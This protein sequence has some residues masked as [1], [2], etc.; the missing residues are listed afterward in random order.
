MAKHKKKKKRQGTGGFGAKKLESE[1]RRAYACAVKKEWSEAC[2]ILEPLSQQYPKSKKVWQY[3][4]GSS[5]EI[6]NMR[7]YQK[8]CEG[9]FKVEPTGENAYGLGGVYL[10]NKHPLMALQ[11]FRQAL[12]L[13]PNHEL[14][15]QAREAVTKLEPILQRTLSEMELR[16]EEGLEIALL[17]E[18]GQAYMEQG[19]YATAR[20]AEEKVL[21][22]HPDMVS[23]RNNLSLIS[24]M[25]GDVE[26][27]MAMAKAVLEREGSNIHA[28]SN[29]IHFL[30]IAGDSAGARVYGEKLKASHAEAWD[31]WSK[32]V[33]GLTY[34][35]DD[36]GIV[37][38]WKQAQAEA[39]EGEE[40]LISALFYHLSAVAL[41]R[42]GSVESARAQWKIALERDASLELARENLRNIGKPISLRHGAWPFK[43]E[44]WLMPKSVAELQQMIKTSVK[45]TQEGKLV[46]RLKDFLAGHAEVVGLLPRILERGGPKG[47]EFVVSTAEQL[48]TPELLNPL[49]EFALSQN[50][51]DQ[52][53]NRAAMLAAQAKLIP[54]DRVR[55]WTAGEW[56]ELMLMAYEFHGETMVKHKRRVESLL[57]SALF[58]LRQSGEKPALEAEA[59]L[60][61]ALVLEPEAP[62]LMYNLTVAFRQQGREEESKAL[63]RD[64]VTRHPDYIFASASLAKLLLEGGD[65]EAAEELL[66]PFLTRDRFHV[67]EFSAFMDAYIE[68][69]LVK[70][71]KKLARS[72]LG[73]WSRVNS[74]VQYKDPQ[75]DYWR[76]R[77]G[78]S[79]KLSQP[80]G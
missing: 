8:A 78:R 1:L 4:L 75:L 24:W 62:D 25:E 76:K 32:K 11:T 41:A 77:L 28:L 47:Q 27:A 16:E 37:E 64:L 36:V 6:G 19:D 39:V 49:K 63:L 15:A 22:K 71:D 66:K 58:L 5:W 30:V 31:G 56:R 42:T 17:H 23:A 3:L 80:F 34:L 7:L 67:L 13:E 33:E 40:E 35:A 53:R 69:M 21:E 29:L 74:Q 68:V 45:A 2:Q 43:W 61:K 38:V 73:M 14:A 59:L 48:K 18:R 44:Q 79:L 65:G 9:L 51:T 70:K 12:E 50:G 20:S 26:G 57:E 52:M 72:W 46:A 10:N 54:K 60:K 55:L